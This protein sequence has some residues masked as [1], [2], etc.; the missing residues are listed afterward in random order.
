M[1]RLTTLVSIAASVALAAP[2]PQITIVSDTIGFLGPA[3]ITITTEGQTE[4]VIAP[5][6]TFIPQDLIPVAESILLKERQ[7]LTIFDTTLGFL[8]PATV[9]VTTDGATVP[10][11][12]P[13]PTFIPPALIPVAESILLKE[14]EAE[15][16]ML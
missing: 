8:G 2:A 7:A 4:T 13:F 5:F 12:V 15:P 9:T 11:V 3:P 1:L 14:R 16:T 6:P 10:V